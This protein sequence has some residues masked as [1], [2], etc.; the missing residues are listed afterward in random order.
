MNYGKEKEMRGKKMTEER[1]KK[2][3]QKN[4]ASAQ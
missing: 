4:K 1:W 3:F 2:N